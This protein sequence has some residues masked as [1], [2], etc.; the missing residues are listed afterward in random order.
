MSQKQQ[1]VI[2]SRM[3]IFIETSIAK[4]FKSKPHI[5]EY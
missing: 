5:L 3:L 4:S 1:I 2:E